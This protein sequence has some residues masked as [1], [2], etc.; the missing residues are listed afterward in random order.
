MGGDM[1]GSRF[2]K[3]RARSHALAESGSVLVEYA[4]V[5]PAFAVGCFFCIQCA[6]LSFQVA[7]FDYAVNSVLT[8]M[9]ADQIERQVE[10][11]DDLDEL[12]KAAFEYTGASI[13]MARLNVS[14]MAADFSNKRES[15]ELSDDDRTEFSI[16]RITQDRRY[17]NL[18]GVVTYTCSVLIPVPGV[19]EVS[20]TKVIKQTK[21]VES[22]FEVS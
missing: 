8:S 2:I 21:L 14:G 7:N 10:D 20:I 11:G 19:S 12:T 6:L 13:D 3:G 17:M 15:E 1:F 9:D 16:S 5:M 22:T 4:F 18:S